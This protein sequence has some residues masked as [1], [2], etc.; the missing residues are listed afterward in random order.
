MLDVRKAQEE[1]LHQAKE[2]QA[3]EEEGAKRV[4]SFGFLSELR[5]SSLNVEA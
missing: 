3:Q 5:V 4:R 1:D 2:D